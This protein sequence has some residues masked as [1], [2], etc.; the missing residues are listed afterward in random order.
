[1]YHISCNTGTRALPDMSTLTLGCCAPSGV[2]C[3]YQAMHSYLCYHYCIFLCMYV[4]MYVHICIYVCMYIIMC[5]GMHVYIHILWIC[6]LQLSLDEPCKVTRKIRVRRRKVTVT[7]SSDDPKTTF[8]CKLDQKEF[9][10]CKYN[11]KCI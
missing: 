6:M 9:E 5:V 1:M 11:Y 8:R 2:V 10:I 3:R 4:H 7:F